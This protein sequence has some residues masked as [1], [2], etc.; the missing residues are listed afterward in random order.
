[1]DELEAMGCASEDGGDDEDDGCED[2]IGDNF[3][4]EDGD[5]EGFLE[6]F[7]EFL[8]R[9]VD[10]ELESEAGEAMLEVAK[11]GCKFTKTY[12]IESKCTG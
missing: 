6:K 9:E 11:E 5:L 12:T 8:G 10:E 7:E 1:M 3:D 2:V 4:Y